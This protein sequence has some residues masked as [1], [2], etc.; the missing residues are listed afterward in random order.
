MTYITNSEEFSG[1]SDQNWTFLT[2]H[3]HVLVCVWRNPLI[4]TREIAVMVGITERS[5]QRI[6]REL[7][8]SQIITTQKDGRKNRYAI[9]PTR[10]L[11]HPL[12][13]HRS[14]ADLLRLVGEIDDETQQTPN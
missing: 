5:V 13:S 14:V 3:S 8:E 2:N 1:K 7:S 12:E 9:D 11:R 6:I 10:M 4:T